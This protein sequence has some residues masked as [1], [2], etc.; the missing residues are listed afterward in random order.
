MLLDRRGVMTVGL[1]H[2]GVEISFNSCLSSKEHRFSI[3]GQDEA[4]SSLEPFVDFLGLESDIVTSKRASSLYLKEMGIQI[5]S[6]IF[7]PGL[8][9]VTV[10]F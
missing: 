1:K 7:V 2:G 6:I 5:C 8:P 3:Q 9:L 4:K 10:V